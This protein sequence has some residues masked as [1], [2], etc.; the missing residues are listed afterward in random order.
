MRNAIYEG[1]CGAS[2]EEKTTQPCFIYFQIAGK[3]IFFLTI[4]LSISY[5]SICMFWI[6]SECPSLTN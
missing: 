4:Q 6:L 5:R 2:F 1:I 3:Q